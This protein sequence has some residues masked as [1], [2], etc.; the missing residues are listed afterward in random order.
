MRGWGAAPYYIAHGDGSEI[1]EFSLGQN[2]SEIL[3]DSQEEVSSKKTE[4]YTS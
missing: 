3:V 4:Q 2:E 1:W